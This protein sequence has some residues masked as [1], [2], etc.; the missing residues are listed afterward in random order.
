MSDVYHKQLWTTHE[1]GPHPEDGK[2]DWEWYPIDHFFY[3][4]YD[5]KSGRGLITGE[6]HK[7]VELECRGNE[8]CI[9]NKGTYERFPTLPEALRRMADIIEGDTNV[10]KN[11]G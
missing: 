4:P 8:Y 3:A 9:D 5:Y 2:G 6:E 11:I 7:I 1:R 10:D